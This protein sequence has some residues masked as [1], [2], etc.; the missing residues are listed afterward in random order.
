MWN[1]IEEKNLPHLYEKYETYRAECDAITD[2]NINR[3]KDIF[4]PVEGLTIDHRFSCRNGYD[5]H[6][7][8]WIVAM[9]YNLE[10]ISMTENNIK[11]PKNSLTISE[12]FVKFGEFLKEHPWYGESFDKSILK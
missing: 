10:W 7:P 5:N 6:I 4:K 1:L 2:I 3:F 11:K 9:P 8:P 12:L